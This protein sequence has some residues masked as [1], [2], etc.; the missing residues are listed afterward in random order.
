MGRLRNGQA[1]SVAL[2]PSGGPA[3]SA[4]RASTAAFSPR[5]SFGDNRRTGPSGPGNRGRSMRRSLLA[6]SI[7]AVLS[8]AV[9]GA[10]AHPTRPAVA[11]PASI[12]LR[13]QQCAREPGRER[14]WRCTGRGAGHLR[15]RRRLGLA[16]AAVEEPGRAGG[17]SSTTTGCSAARRA[18]TAST[19]PRRCAW[20]GFP[21]F[22]QNC[23]EGQQG[24]PGPGL[25]EGRFL[26][27]R[28]RRRPP[29]PARGAPVQGDLGVDTVLSGVEV[30]TATQA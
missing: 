16:G 4:G 7:A 26:P 8:R 10:T 11:R 14:T 2:R 13:R 20:P 6:L 28:L 12:D 1:R 15:L 18:R 5:R 17:A 25:A 19:I 9:P 23:L 3:L 27:R 29:P 22:D 30:G 21:A 24:Q